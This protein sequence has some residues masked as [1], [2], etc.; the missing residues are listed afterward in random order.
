ML[1]LVEIDPVILEKK[2]KILKKKVYD[3]NDD[4]GGQG[5][6]IDQKTSFEPFYQM[7]FK[8]NVFFSLYIRNLI[9]GLSMTNVKISHTVI[10][11]SKVKYVYVIII[12]INHEL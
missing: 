1:R 10:S 8:K 2:T 12:F 9:I 3:N 11:R 7:N 4:D 5:A 6:N